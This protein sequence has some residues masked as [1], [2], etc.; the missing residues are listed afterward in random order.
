[1]CRRPSIIESSLLRL[2]LNIE[3]FEHRLKRNKEKKNTQRYSFELMISWLNHRWIAVYQTHF[4]SKP[5][6]VSFY[7]C[8]W[9]TLSWVTSTVIRSKMYKV[10]MTHIHMPEQLKSSIQEREKK[11]KHTTNRKKKFS[12]PLSKHSHTHIRSNWH[13]LHSSTFLFQTKADAKS[14]TP[15][16]D[17]H[18]K[19]REREM[20]RQ[21]KIEI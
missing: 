6:I 8:V 18:R 5:F 14:R 7:V 4:I 17:T 12:W 3:P 20:E 1:M 9:R 21:K 11:P 2:I 10:M 13:V 16:S 15:C 19:W